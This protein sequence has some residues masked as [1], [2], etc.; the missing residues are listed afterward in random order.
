MENRRI[1]LDDWLTKSYTKQGLPLSNIVS[2]DC[3]YQ[4]P[5]KDNNSV[6]RL[7]ASSVRAILDCDWYPSCRDSI[8]GVRK[9]FV[10]V[11]DIK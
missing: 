6:A 2:G 5:M 10:R 9:C 8:L 1:S 7:N 3:Y 4:A 11:E